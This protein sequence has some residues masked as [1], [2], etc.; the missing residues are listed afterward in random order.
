MELRD[1]TTLAKNNAMREEA[2]LAMQP[3]FQPPSAA[4]AW[5]GDT[6]KKLGISFVPKREESLIALLKTRIRSTWIRSHEEGISYF[7]RVF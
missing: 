4:S 7:A 1:R 6:L 3:Q 5:D 2:K